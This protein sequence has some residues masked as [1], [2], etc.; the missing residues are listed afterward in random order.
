[1]KSTV[2]WTKKMLCMLLAFV[3][4]LQ[5]AHL[6]IVAIGSEISAALASGTESGGTQGVLPDA[7]N[8]QWQIPEAS[9]NPNAV[10][11]TINNGIV[12]TDQVYQELIRWGYILGYQGAG[13]PLSRGGWRDF[14]ASLSPLAPLERTGR[15]NNNKGTWID[16]DYVTTVVK[17]SNGEYGIYKNLVTPT[18]TLGGSYNI[19][20]GYINRKYIENMIIASGANLDQ[21]TFRLG[22]IAGSS[23][24]IGYTNYDHA[25]NLLYSFTPNTRGSMIRADIN[26]ADFYEKH[27]AIPTA[28]LY[29]D[30]SQH[31]MYDIH[32]VFI[33]N[34]SPSI[35]SVD[36]TQEG[37]QLVVTL[38]TNEGVRWS[39][40]TVS[41]Q[42]NDIW[43]EVELQVIGTEYT[44]RVR[45]HIADIDYQYKVN[46]SDPS[47]SDY[48][49]EIVFKGD[50]GPFA[51]LDYK[52]VDI[53]NYSMPKQDYPITFGKLLMCCALVK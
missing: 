32:A 41:S 8:G 33:D 40:D 18:L 21:A 22:A 28:Y 51:D 3:F 45:A 16:N 17:R 30:G 9:E 10:D 47:K 50:L 38:K 19:E 29:V 13:D 43:V 27:S 12:Y 20:R 52:V 15:I 7:D 5:L 44:Q 2:R 34:T 49:N 6:T 26:I 1:M 31:T 53:T 48:S 39:A 23:A 35:Q 36:V 46:T 42:L 37:D 24:Y 11:M 4:T 14:T 25:T